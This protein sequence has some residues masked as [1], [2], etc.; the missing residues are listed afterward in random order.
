MAERARDDEYME[1]ILNAFKE[2]GGVLKKSDGIGA[3]TQRFS[4]SEAEAE[5]ILDQY[6]DDFT[7]KERAKLNEEWQEKLGVSLPEPDRE[8]DE[9]APTVERPTQDE[10][11]SAIRDAF[12]KSGKLHRDTAVKVFETEFDLDREAA[13]A[14]VRRYA[15][16]NDAGWSRPHPSEEMTF[17]SDLGSLDQY[18]GLETGRRWNGLPV[19]EAEEGNEHPLIPDQDVYLDRVVEGQTTDAEVLAKAMADPDFSPLLVGDAGTGKDTL[20]RYVCAKT[21]RPCVRVNFGEDVRYADLVGT[22]MPA[23]NDDGEGIDIVWEDG[24]LTHAVK[25]GYV[26]IADEIN[27]APPEATMP[28][29]QVTEEGDDAEL[30]IREES[31][32]VTPHPQFR[33]VATMNPPRGGYGGVEQLNDAFKSRFY[34][35]EVDYLEPEDE[36]KLLRERFED[37]AIDVTDSEI[38]QL[39]ELAAGFREQYQRGD[40]VTPVTTRELIKV[41]KMSDIMSMK[42]AA[43][44]VIGGHAKE[45]DERL[46]VDR[47]NTELS[48]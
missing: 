14:E 3:L 18:P 23:G 28:L 2:N 17:A 19:L 40:I 1:A 27:A 8:S 10:A 20:V 6:I 45:N 11:E 37:D 46:I 15:S 4:L 39:T 36:A 29:H 7:G 13:I 41:C 35:I 25:Y 24:I 33:F 38:T 32:I 26:F 30:V 22:R 48:S 42:Q 34:T 43:R 9:S 5:D 21:N 16:F 44:M 31:R 12:N 47:I